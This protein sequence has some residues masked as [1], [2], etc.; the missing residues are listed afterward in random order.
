MPMERLRTKDFRALLEFVRKLY[1]VR[2]LEGFITTV[3]TSLPTAIRS[4]IT[5]YNEINPSK[6][7]SHDRGSGRWSAAASQAWQTVIH[8]HPPL[9]HALCTKSQ[10]KFYKLINIDQMMGFLI[11]AQPPNGIGIALHRQHR[12]F[13]ERDRLLFDLARCHLIGA[14]RN[15]QALAKMRTEMMLLKQTLENVKQGIIV[16]DRQGT[17][18]FANTI[19][20]QWLLKYFS[21]GIRNNVLPDALRVWANRQDAVLDQTDDAPP[22]RIPLSITTASKRLTVRLLSDSD[23]WTY[24]LNEENLEIQPALLAPLGLSRRENEILSWIAYGKTNVEIGMILNV[25]PRTVQKHLER[26]Y[27]KLGVENRTAAAARAYEL[28]ATGSV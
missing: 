6:G 7:R 9:L 10:E 3:L 20:R 15:V 14:Y 16:S 2:D 11:R 23:R 24:L 5:T 8:E 27:Q 22:A 19:A 21:V 17:V 25:S 26:I 1:S 13:D 28:V 18:H 12:D 4:D